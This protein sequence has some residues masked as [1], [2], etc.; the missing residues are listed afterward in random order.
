M[1]TTTAL[2]ATTVVVDAGATPLGRLVVAAARTDPQVH[3]VVGPSG[4]TGDVAG[5]PIDVVLLASGSGPDRDG[6]GSGD[7]GLESAAAFLGSL[8]GV[9]V[10]SL[11]VLSSAMVYGAWPDNPLPISEDAVLRPNPESTYATAKA[12]LERL[13]DAFAV[14]HPSTA[15][16]VLRPT[17]TTSNDPD[18][19]DW[20]GRSLWHVATAR[21]GDADPAGQFLHIDDLASALD[22]ARRHAL[23]GAF[24]VAPEGWLS[25]SRQVELVGRGGRVR[26]PAASAG[27]VAALRWRLGLTSTP[28]EVLPFT[29][30][31]W[32][33]ASDRL[34][35]TGWTP[36]SS[37]EEALVVGSRPGWWA[38]LSARRR[39]ELSLGILVGGVAAV[40]TG[41]VAVVRR[42]MRRT[43]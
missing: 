36:R 32:V 17:V 31:S 40:A 2:A 29:M 7:V 42:A 11:V 12:E 15:I 20:M 37:N 16:A 5:G 28:P 4:L 13:A 26:I 33:V 10:R 35:A 3:R 24:N 27:R 25:A 22:H 30:H 18:A 19:V 34:R 38:S 14:T 39:Q 21:H 1:A 43:D 8:D 6:S 41:T 9:A 23:D